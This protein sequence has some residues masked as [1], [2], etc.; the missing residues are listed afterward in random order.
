MKLALLIYFIFT[1]EGSLRKRMANLQTRSAQE[2][3]FTNFI[4]STHLRKLE[5]YL[6]Q[7]EHERYRTLDDINS[8]DS[9]F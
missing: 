1:A 2:D 6:Q 5:E 8:M 3:D 4:L 9:Y 7:A